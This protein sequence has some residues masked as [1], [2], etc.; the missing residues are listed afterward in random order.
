MTYQITANELWGQ[1]KLT[2]KVEVLFF[3]TS[4]ELSVERRLAG[5]G[6]S[7]GSSSSTSSIG[8]SPE[9]MAINWLIDSHANNTPKTLS[10]AGG[11]FEDLMSLD[12]WTE[13]TEA[14]ASIPV[15]I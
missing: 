5:G 11:N 7:S 3:S 12:D 10:T 15:S 1:A 13:Y 8:S 9:S 2:V 4:V 14:F 6:S